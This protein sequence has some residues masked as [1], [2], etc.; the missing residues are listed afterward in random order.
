MERLT[1]FHDGIWG[2]SVKATEQGCDRYTALS[3][4]AKYEDTGLSPEQ[5]QEV[6]GKQVPKPL[7]YRGAVISCV[8]CPTCGR[9]Y[10]DEILV[11]PY[12]DMCGQK[13]REGK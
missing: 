3:R 7:K 10:F 9:L 11:M 5:M 8:C 13:L 1:E 6:K 2:L 4:L 12:C